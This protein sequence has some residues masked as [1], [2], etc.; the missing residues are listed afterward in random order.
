MYD[1]NYDDDSDE[2]DNKAPHSKAGDDTDYEDDYYND[3]V[4]SLNNT[5]KAQVDVVFFNRC[6][7]V[8]SQSLME[9]MGRLAKRNNFKH[10]RNV[11]K[12]RSTI[13][14]KPHEQMELIKEI[15]EKPRPHIYSQH[16][17]YINFTQ[18]RAPRPI[19]I[20]L[21]RD[22][23][24]RVRSWFYYVRA[25]WYYIDMRRHLGDKAP[26]MPPKEFMEM[27]LDTCVKTHNVHCQYKQMDNT[28]GDYRRQTMF[29]CGQNR[30]LCM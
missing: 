5:R 4:D 18:F 11:A 12:S 17:N 26:P 24:E 21:I 23:L 15:Y 14:I 7:K 3:L 2:L 29:F 9:L 10:S 13:Y 1:D 20:N 27:D 30:K 28:D 25:E 6:A 8:G 16:I 19:Y 22:P